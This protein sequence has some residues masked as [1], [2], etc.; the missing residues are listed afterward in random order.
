V[1]RFVAIVAQVTV[2]R[3]FNVELMRRGGFS[4]G[5]WDECGLKRNDTL[6][7]RLQNKK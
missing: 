6:P 3:K 1:R 5:L 2:T 7:E 4:C